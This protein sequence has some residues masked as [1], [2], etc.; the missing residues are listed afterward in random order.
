[1]SCRNAGGEAT[2]R[3][4]SMLGKWNSYSIWLDPNSIAPS[5]P[6]ATC[7]CRRTSREAAAGEADKAS[8]Q[9]MFATKDGAVAAPTAGLHFTERLIAKID[10]RGISRHVVTLHV[11]AGT[12]LLP[13]KADDTSGHKMHSEWVRSMPQRRLR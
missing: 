3:R 11:G 13:V 2:S 8:Y 4:S 10:A 1:M 6:L 12:F 9:T 5:R 7:R